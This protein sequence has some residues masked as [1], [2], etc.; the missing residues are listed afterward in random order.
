MRERSGPDNTSQPGW[1]ELAVRGPDG[2]ETLSF[3]PYSLSR[4]L[5]QWAV[6]ADNLLLHKESC[7]SD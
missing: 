4:L 6:V 3:F 2:L 1:F 7:D 5:A